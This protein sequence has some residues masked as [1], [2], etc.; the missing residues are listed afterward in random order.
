MPDA[1]VSGRARGVGCDADQPGL[2]QPDRQRGG[3]RRPWSHGHGRNSRGRGECHDYAPQPRCCNPGG[4]TH[5]DLQRDEGEKG[6]PEALIQWTDRKSGPGAL[7]RRADRASAPGANSSGLHR[8]RKAPR[9]PSICPGAHS[10]RAIAAGNFRHACLYPQPRCGAMFR[11]E[12]CEADTCRPEQEDEH[13]RSRKRSVPAPV[14]FLMP[15]A[16]GHSGNYP[17]CLVLERYVGVSP[18]PTPAQQRTWTF[19]VRVLFCCPEAWL[20]DPT[21]S[22]FGAV[23]IVH[24]REF[25]CSRMA[26]LDDEIA[27]SDG[28]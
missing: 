17:L 11:W 9:S 28:P 1:D 16:I 12:R 24:E 13:R 6:T 27:R 19:V 15:I 7:H 18:S 23:R 3:A 14:G 21:N 25:V 22:A 5:G 20:L 26:V 8:R 2:N 10:I 4:P